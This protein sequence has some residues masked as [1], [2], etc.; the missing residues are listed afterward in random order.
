MDEE[1]GFFAKRTRQRDLGA[2]RSEPQQRQH[3]GAQHHVAD[4]AVAD[5]GLGVDA[6]ARGVGVDG[7]RLGAQRDQLGMPSDQLAYRRLEGQLTLR[8][9]R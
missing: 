1:A 5:P 9:R 6:H 2:A 3:L 4:L 8:W 7:G